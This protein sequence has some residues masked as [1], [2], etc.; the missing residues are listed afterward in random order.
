MADTAP[1]ADNVFFEDQ[2]PALS[3]SRAELL[4]GLQ[5]QQ[6]QI[7]PKF[8]YDAR[9]SELFEQITQLPEYYPTRTE[10]AILVEN[11]AEIAGCCGSD[12]V[13]IEP[14]SGS[15]EKVRLLLDVLQPVAYMP[16][17]IC[18]E[19]LYESALKLGREFPWL[20][21]YPICTDF[22]DHWKMHAELPAGRRVVFYP[23]STI[24]NLE[25]QDAQVFLSELRQWI[26]D[27]GGVI[28]GVDLH[29]SEKLLNAAYNDAEGVTAEFNLNILNS[30]NRIT[31]ADFRRQN[32]SHRAF[33]NR[34][35]RRVEMHL[36]SKESQVVKV[37]GSSIAFRKGETLHTENSYKY[38]LESFAGLTRTAGLTLNKSWVD[39]ENLFSVHYLA[40]A[41]S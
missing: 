36:E 4:A 33:Y 7:N 16:L 27:D 40:V 37:N 18:A 2:L 24:G 15:S 17:D 10:R 1:S 14:G 8:F 19:I 6:K 13:L 22:S 29:K 28:I 41:E 34:E 30:M 20:S 38:S 39:E 25:P 35:L 9:G 32:F 11:A 26:G 3:D 23:G 21:V 5:L 12:C 31:D